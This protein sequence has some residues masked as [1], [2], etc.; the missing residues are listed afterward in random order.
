MCDLS[1]L[2][3]ALN[4][5][6]NLELLL[7][8]LL[9]V[10]RKCG[11]A[12]EILVLDGGS[13]DGTQ[14]IACRL[15][16]RVVTQTERGY[17]GA[18]LAGFAAATGDV[19]ITMDADLSHPVEFIETLWKHRDKAEILVASRYVKGGASDVHWFRSVLSWILNQTYRRLLSLPIHDLSSGFRLYHRDAI[20]DLAPRA[21][22][23]DFLEET[24]IVAFLKSK[25]VAEIP[26]HY[27]PR[28]NGRSHAKLLKFGMAYL[29]T[30][31]RMWMLRRWNLNDSTICELRTPKYV[32][33]KL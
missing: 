17:G 18:M 26:F 22:D 2:I 28:G 12:A 1:I 3:P 20:R 7:P 5:R 15:G 6:L 10:I 19:L 4:E 33:V 32:V 16:A 31:R 13:S 11:I 27:L 8:S 29:K 25:S 9:Q 30:L 14:E 23:F 24:L 21:R